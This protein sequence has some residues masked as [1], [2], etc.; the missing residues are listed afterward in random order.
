MKQG[1]VLALLAFFLAS[2]QGN[3]PEI[4]PGQLYRITTTRDF[5]CAKFVKISG[6]R[7][8]GTY[9]VSEGN[10]LADKRDVTLVSARKLYLMDASGSKTP[11]IDCSE[12][13]EPLFQAFPKTWEYRDSVYAVREMQDVPFARAKG[14]WSSFPDTGESNLDIFLSRVSSLEMSE[15]QLTMDVYLPKDEGKVSRPLLVLIHGGAFYNGDKASLGFPELGRFF[16]GMGYVVASVNYRLGFHLNTLSVERAGFRAVQDVNAAIARILYDSDT[17]RVD[18]QRVFVAG[19]SA[20]GITALNVAFMRDVNIPRSARNEGGVQAVNADI[21]QPFS[22]R[23]VGN[24]WGA[25]GDTTILRNAPT[26]ILSF[27]STGDPIVPFGQDHPF[28][29]VFGNRVIFPT[30]YGSGVISSLVGRSRSQLHSYDLPGVHTLHIDRGWDGVEYLN[31][32]FLEMKT[33]MRDFFSDRMLPHP[34]VIRSKPYSNVLQV[35]CSD[36]KSIYWK[37]SGGIVLQQGEGEASV[38]FFPNRTSHSVTVSGQYKSG[39]TFC[40]TFNY[41]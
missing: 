2:C 8:A 7:W 27:H 11:V 31:D 14:Y 25:V 29:S 24:M 12:Y 32:R 18:P 1:C 15:L 10:L 41:D 35:D 21:A 40:K 13:E 9:Y 19:T 34:V 4:K 6:N 38:L 37:V 5:G 33:G 22:I 28:E 17:Y 23:A 26:A 30:M 3:G 39:L 36:I 16:A 20:G